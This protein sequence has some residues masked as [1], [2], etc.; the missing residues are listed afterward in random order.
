MKRAQQDGDEWA[1]IYALHI[2][3]GKEKDAAEAAAAATQAARLKSALA[4]Q[5]GG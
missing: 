4:R 3:Q 5:V 2:M 1:K